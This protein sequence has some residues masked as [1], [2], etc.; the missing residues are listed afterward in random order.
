MLACPGPE[1]Y[2]TPDRTAETWWDSPIHFDVLYADGDSS[3][4]ACSAHG[5]RGGANERGKKRKSNSSP[6]AASAVICVTFQ[7]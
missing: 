4:I 7:S 1:P 2:W 3:S 6:D 5:V